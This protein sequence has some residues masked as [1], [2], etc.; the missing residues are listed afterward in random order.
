M[1]GLSTLSA[2]S[3]DSRQRNVLIL[4]QAYDLILPTIRQNDYEESSGV[5]NNRR[6][7]DHEW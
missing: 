5:R 7:Y 6:T 2:L 1:L 3:E 4:H